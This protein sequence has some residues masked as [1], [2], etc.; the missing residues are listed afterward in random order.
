MFEENYRYHLYTRMY[1]A[2]HR[3]RNFQASNTKAEGYI[4]IVLATDQMTNTVQ[5]TVPTA[6]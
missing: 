3:T 2:H 4:K 1:N 6:A 5:P